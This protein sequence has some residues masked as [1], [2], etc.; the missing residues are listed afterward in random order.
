MK[1]EENKQLKSRLMKFKSSGKLPLFLSS[2]T[3]SGRPKDDQ[4]I[5]KD[6]YQTPNIEIKSKKSKKAIFSIEPSIA[7][8]KILLYCKEDLEVIESWDDA[9]CKGMMAIN[10]YKKIGGRLLGSYEYNT[11]KPK[12]VSD[13]YWENVSKKM[14]VNLSKKEFEEVFGAERYEIID[15]EKIVDLLSSVEFKY[16]KDKNE[17]IVQTTASMIKEIEKVDKKVVTYIKKSLEQKRHQEILESLSNKNNNQ[18]VG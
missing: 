3:N 8:D 6:L 9:I 15:K 16:K 14:Q 18:N 17:Y 12:M 5:E 13:L 11:K 1:K 7:S 2:T 10:N 4:V